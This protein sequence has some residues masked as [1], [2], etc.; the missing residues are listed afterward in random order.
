ML[1]IPITVVIYIGIIFIAVTR[2]RIQF[3]CKAFCHGNRD[4]KKIAFTFD[5]GPDPQTTPALIHILREHQIKA[6]FFVIGEKAQKYPAIIKQ[7]TDA[8]HLVANHSYTHPWHLN[9]F[10]STALE[11]QILQTKTILQKITGSDS[12]FFRPPMG[13]TN[14]HYRSILKKN[15]ITVVG[16]DVRT[17]DKYRNKHQIIEKIFKKKRNGSIILM[18]DSDVS[19]EKLL[20]IISTVAEKLRAQGYSFIRIDQMVTESKTG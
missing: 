10:F 6:T 9:F 12:L 8:G 15:N 14:P 7:L 11:K 1:T 13:L 5:D 20:D 3:F 19:I 18:H 4:Q 17:F 2:L 16:W